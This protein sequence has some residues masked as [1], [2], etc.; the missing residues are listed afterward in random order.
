MDQH[1]K[2]TVITKPL[3]IV[4]CTALA[5]FAAIAYVGFRIAQRDATFEADFWFKWFGASAAIFFALVGPFGLI[6]LWNM[7]L[8]GSKKG[9]TDGGIVYRLIFGAIAS[10]ALTAWVLNRFNA[11]ELFF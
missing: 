8:M 10:L 4:S 5:L 3:V 9:D 2:H 11:Y 6:G 7:G 1:S